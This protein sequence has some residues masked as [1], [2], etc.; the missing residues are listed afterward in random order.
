MTVVVPA[1]P[2]RDRVYAPRSLGSP[3]QVRHASVYD[4][5]DDLLFGITENY[6]GSAPM[7]FD[8][9][10][11]TYQELLGRVLESG[12]SVVPFVGAGLS[13]YGRQDQRLPLWRELLELLIAEGKETGLI[14]DDGD[15][16]ID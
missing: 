7:T 12:A 8:T 6:R 4:G 11:A 13:V 1:I 5:P 10:N 9:S 16:V 15:P 3:S 2:G 14:P